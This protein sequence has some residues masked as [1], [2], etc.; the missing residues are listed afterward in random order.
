MRQLA[1][2]DARSNA[3]GYHA[4]PPH[5]W[6]C[7]D[8]LVAFFTIIAKHSRIGEPPRSHQGDERST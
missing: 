3:S 8:C 5:Q 4:I 1:A 7:D 6:V 2:A